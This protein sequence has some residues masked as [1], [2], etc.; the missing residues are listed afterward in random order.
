MLSIEKTKYIITK[1]DSSCLVFTSTF[2]ILPIMWALSNNLWFHSAVSF[3]TLFFSILYWWHPIHSLRRTVDIY[4]AK[5]CFLFYLTSGMFHV[6]YGMPAAI[7][8][9]GAS[10]I[11]ISYAM[12]YVF[13]RI[14]LRFHVMVHLL[15]VAMKLYVIYFV[16]H[17]IDNYLLENGIF[18]N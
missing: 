8:Y 5:W 12:T 6:P 16:A 18:K 17:N 7:L 13:P 2:N 9:I 3:G 15:S 11:A 14:W 10:S 1:F 4:Y